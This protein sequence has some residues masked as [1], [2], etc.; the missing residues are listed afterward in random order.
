[1]VNDKGEYTLLREMADAVVKFLLLNLKQLLLYHVDLL[2]GVKDQVESLHRELSL[3]KAFLKDSR[4]KRS[5][6]EYVRELV[7]QINIVAYEAEDIIDT[8][9]TNAAMQKARSTVRR[10][11]H[12]F[13]HSSKLRN[14]AKEIESI[15]VR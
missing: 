15:K 13:D 12:V 10:A 5:E 14:V 1:M 7:S 4:E 3:M 2:S 9:V 8:F 6:Y 11:F